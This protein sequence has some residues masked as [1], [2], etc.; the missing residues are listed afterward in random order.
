MNN[1]SSKAQFA[2]IVNS[3]RE[4]QTQRASMA[5]TIGEIR[6]LQTSMANTLRELHASCDSR[7]SRSSNTSSNQS[8]A[9]A[10][11]NISTRT[12]MDGTKIIKF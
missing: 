12:L 2:S 6:T 10:T 8:Q 9:N 5:T 7:L 3:I 4:I 1:N 11:N